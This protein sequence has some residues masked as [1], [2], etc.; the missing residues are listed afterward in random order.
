MIFSTICLVF[1]NINAVWVA[2]GLAEFADLVELGL[3]LSLGFI[4]L[5]QNSKLIINL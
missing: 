2:F 3:R 5:I 4:Q 1:K